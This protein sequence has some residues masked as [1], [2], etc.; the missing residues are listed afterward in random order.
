MDSIIAPRPR[1]A[2][3]IANMAS[4]SNV[5][6]H[7]SWVRKGEHEYTQQYGFQEL[8][9]NAISAPPASPALFLPFSHVT[10]KNVKAGDKLSDHS[11]ALCF[12]TAWLQL[13]Q[14]HPQLA[15]VNLR[16]AKT[17]K[18]PSSR[19][20]LEEWLDATFIV[21]PDTTADE[22]WRTAVKPRQLSLYFLPQER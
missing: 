9:Y 5:K 22:V 16:E 21:L 8:L 13:R 4:P 19:A 7:S 17:Y 20:E 3:N 11:L 6:F 2:S 1:K 18:S 10:F 12:R 14:S 15:A